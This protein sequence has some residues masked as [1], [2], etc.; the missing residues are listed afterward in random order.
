MHSVV[1]SVPRRSELTIN[2]SLFLQ[3]S[4]MKIAVSGKGGVGKTTLVALLA[5]AWAK[6]GYKVLAV[7]AD[8][9]PHLG[10]ALGFPE[11]EKIVPVIQ[12][13]ELIE[14]RTGAKVGQTGQIFRLNP[15]VDDLPDKFCAE[16]RGIKLVVMGYIEQGGR[17]CACPENKFLSALLQHL[18][19]QRDEMVILDMVAGIE[20]LG[21]ATV[22]AVDA[23]IT[24]IEPGLRS[25]ETARK[26]SKLANDLGIKKIW[27]VANKIRNDK[28][29]R[30]IE[31]H[32]DNL[33][34]VAF[35]P[36]NGQIME[37]DRRVP[38]EI[39][40]PQVI[41]EIEQIRETIASTN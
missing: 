18:L 9:D 16:H 33:K 38:S 20:H 24:V 21:R 32:S 31:E 29:K 10:L 28:E 7:D 6:D 37:N 17:G 11:P 13:K 23:M 12:M 1:I 27:T 15:K 39:N 2:C 22:Q 36:F 8:P 35:V 5:R 3:L 14:E 30:F 41:Q 40:N 25:L 26:I 4:L 19:I 34:M